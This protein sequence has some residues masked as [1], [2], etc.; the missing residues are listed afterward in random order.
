MG[1]F[2]LQCR[3]WQAASF[4]PIRKG[5]VAVIFTRDR[6]EAVC[7]GAGQAALASQRISLTLYAASQP[8]W[9]TWSRG[10]RR[11][12]L[13]P[14]NSVRFVWWHSALLSPGYEDARLWRESKN[15]RSKKPTWRAPCDYFSCRLNFL[16]VFFFACD[17]GTHR[18]WM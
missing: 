3:Q 11:V 9:G 5:S 2:R 6:E 10:K 7:G 12:E 13:C 15:Q 18:W 14:Q 16:I 1:Q 17:L 8:A 4:L